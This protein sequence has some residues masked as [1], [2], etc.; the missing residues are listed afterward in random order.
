MDD[1]NTQPG[2]GEESWGEL[3]AAAQRGD[4][5]AYEKLLHEILPVLR[6][7][8]RTRVRDAANAEDVVQNVLM[9]IHR[10]RRTYQPG[11][12][13]GPWMRTI[14]RN[15]ALDS[16][17]S[18]SARLRREVPLGD[19]EVPDLADDGV[20]EESL[21]DEMRG[22]LDSLPPGQRQAV[23]LIHVEQLSVREAAERVGITPG[24]LKVR[25]HRGYK[26]L[27]DLLRRNP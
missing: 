4:R 5:A 22:A 9:S 15:A 3:M 13:F 8:V 19:V 12:P 20:A 26:T 21:S 11:R 7:F 2:A 6:A 16:H 25:A 24:A 14:A 17:R 1:R 23:E 10:A 18:R 27:R